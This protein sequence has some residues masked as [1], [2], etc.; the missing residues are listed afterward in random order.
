MRLTKPRIP[1]WRLLLVT[2]VF[3]FP[4][5]PKSWRLTVASQAICF[6]TMVIIVA[7]ATFLA[8]T[9]LRARRKPLVA[10]K[11]STPPTSPMPPTCPR[12]DFSDITWEFRGEMKASWT[13]LD[14]YI[15]PDIFSFNRNPFG[16]T[17]H[18]TLTRPTARELPRVLGT[19][20][21]ESF[22]PAYS[23]SLDPKL[24]RS[25]ARYFGNFLQHRN[26]RYTSSF[27]LCLKVR[28]S[29]PFSPEEPP[30]VAM[31]NDGWLSNGTDLGF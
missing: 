6:V 25:H 1:P 2:G 17:P 10:R 4:P 5:T 26:R 13:A 19:F 7:T 30:F 18:D 8:H 31:V 16:D 28:C 3:L 14:A 15:D 20:P 29:I 27:T 11:R 21:K 12:P 9:G 22:R 23:L 24:L